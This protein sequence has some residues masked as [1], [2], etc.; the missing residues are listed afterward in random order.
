MTIAFSARG[1]RLLRPIERL[2]PTAATLLW[3]PYVLPVGW[4]VVVLL[5]IEFGAFAVLATA[6]HGRLAL[7]RP[8]E[9]NL[10][11]FYLVLSAGGV[12]ATGLVA[13]A[14]PLIFS[15]ILEYPILVATATG[16]LALLAGPVP[17][18]DTRGARVV[19]VGIGAPAAAVRGDRRPALRRRRAGEPRSGGGGRGRPARRGRAPGGRREDVRE[20][21]GADDG[22]DRGLPR[23]DREQ[24]A[25][26]GS[27]RSSASPR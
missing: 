24:P 16:V 14:A 17:R 12:L 20:P 10:T 23:G 3:I 4:P 19:L 13:L 9:G 11:G 6:I 27:G 7:D 21:R 15:T 1:R 25:P 2:V 5:A 8:D 22:C 18:D 26:P